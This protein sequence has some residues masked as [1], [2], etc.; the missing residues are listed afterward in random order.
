MSHG[1]GKV[2][3]CVRPA[4]S[5]P[6]RNRIALAELIREVFKIGLDRD[7]TEAERAK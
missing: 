7:P 4:L 2:E 1:A 5:D 3:R 6:A